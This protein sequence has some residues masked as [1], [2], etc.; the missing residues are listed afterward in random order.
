MG[1]FARGTQALADV[2]VA[3]VDHREIFLAW[4]DIARPTQIAPPMPYWIWIIMAGRGWGKNRTGAEWV[5]ELVFEQGVK[6][7]ALIGRTASDVRDTMLNNPGS[8]LL[9]IFPPSQQPVWEPSK[10]LITWPNGAR[11]ITFSAD[12]PDQLRGPQFEAVWGDEVSTW[13]YPESLDNALLALR[14]GEVPRMLLTMTPKPTR[15]VR[16]LVS[17]DGEDLVHVTRGATIDNEANLA[18]SVVRQLHARYEGTR[19]ER[20]ELFGE[21]IEDAEGA[22]WHREQIE[23]DRA[24]WQLDNARGM[25]TVCDEFHDADSCP[26]DVHLVKVVVSIDPGG[27]SETSHPT[28]IAVVALGDDGDYYVL[29]AGQHRVLPHIWARMAVRYFDVYEANYLTAEKNF[30]GDM[31]EGTIRNERQGVPVTPVVSKRGKFLRADPISQLYAQHHV[32][33][34]GV[35]ADLEDQQCAFVDG[36]GDGDPTGGD[37]DALDAVVQG[38]TDLTS[39]TE[40]GVA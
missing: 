29:E 7:L 11:A 15:L 27:S 32:H 8:G 35:L 19:M 6:N 21:L 37:W 31:V 10:R 30:G 36:I 3:P 33:H 34:L 4:K 17:R 14:L 16:E 24:S 22:L 25:R 39:G 28:G 2:L 38:L 12:K 13:R 20:Q 40:W 5:R 1:N 18:P 26:R 23:A 9:N